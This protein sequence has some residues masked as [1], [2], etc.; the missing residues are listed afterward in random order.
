MQATTILI[1]LS[2]AGLFGIISA[3]AND[4]RWLIGFGLFLLIFSLGMIEN[5]GISYQTGTDITKTNV[6]TST[7]FINETARYTD[8]TTKYTFPISETIYTGSIV[9]VVAAFLIASNLKGMNIL[10]LFRK[11]K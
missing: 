5:P 6:S 11:S 9:L 4:R 10:K 8:I 7:T 2:I 1:F 3:T